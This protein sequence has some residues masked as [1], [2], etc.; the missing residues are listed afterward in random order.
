MRSG[1]AHLCLLSQLKLSPKIHI[2]GPELYPEDPA[3]KP[4]QGLGSIVDTL[5][6]FQKVLHKLPRGHV[7]QLRIEVSTLLGHFKERMTLMHCTPKETANGSPVNTFTEKYATH[8]ITF[9]YMALDRLKQFM[10]KL[11]VNLDQL[12]S[13]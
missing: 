10:Q 9:G 12:K 1:H 3:D 2:V 6:N 8:H 11:K 13:C 4:I 7:T 5:T